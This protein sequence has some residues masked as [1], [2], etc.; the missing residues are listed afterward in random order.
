[1]PGELQSD[2][3]NVWDI[4]EIKPNIVEKLKRQSCDFIGFSTRHMS[5]LV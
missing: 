3:E 4:K 5:S 1:M 2:R